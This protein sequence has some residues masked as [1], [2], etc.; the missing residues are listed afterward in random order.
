MI[1]GR[2]FLR[3][4]GCALNFPSGKVHIRVIGQEFEVLTPEDRPA[5]YRPLR[6]PVRYVGPDLTLPS[7]TEAKIR[8]HIGTR[9]RICANSSGIFEPTPVLYRAIKVKAAAGITEV[10]ANGGAEILLINGDPDQRR[11]KRGTIVGVWTEQGSYRLNGTSSDPTNS[12]S[13]NSVQVDDGSSVPSESTQEDGSSSSS[14]SSS[15]RG[16]DDVK[17]TEDGLLLDQV[18]GETSP[19]AQLDLYYED[20]SRQYEDGIIFDILAFSS[21]DSQQHSLYSLKGR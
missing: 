6:L 17:N 8:C 16:D 11:I 2:D 19:L 4:A 13:I 12:N 21:N 20:A 15:P 9:S 7:C 3:A 10:N 5:S 14:S 18:V 1:L